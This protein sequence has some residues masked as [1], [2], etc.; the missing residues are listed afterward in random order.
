MLA[1]VCILAQPASADFLG[2]FA[3]TDSIII[4]IPQM[5]DTLGRPITPDSIQVSAVH[6]STAIHVFS[7]RS[8]S[9]PLFA[10]L[11]GADTIT[12]YASNPYLF[13]KDQVTNY[14][15]AQTTGYYLFNI[16]QFKTQGAVTIKQEAQHTFMVVATSPYITNDTSVWANSND[17]FLNVDTNVV[18]TSVYWGLLINRLWEIALRVGGLGDSTVQ[19]LYPLNGTAPKDSVQTW[20]FRNGTFQHLQTLIYHR[21]GNV[22]DSTEVKTQY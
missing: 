19:Y 15:G 2:L 14:N 9:P 13:L 18:D 7:D 6:S 11:Q 20:G 8:I 4:P 12:A 5:L 22:Y 10:D 16:D 1:V 21:S 3:Q 17:L